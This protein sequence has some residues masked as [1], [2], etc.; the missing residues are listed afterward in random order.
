MSDQPTLSRRDRRRLQTRAEILAAARELLLEVGPEE[1][2]LRQVARR[3]D[4]SPAALY[5][6]FG[7]R[8]EIVG[9]LF[10]EAFEN[11]DA[12]LR[13]VPASLSPEKR[14]VELALAYMDFA[15]E[16]PMDLRCMLLSTSLE[17]PP[18]SAKAVGMG[19]ARL[20]GETFRAGMEQGYFPAGGPLSA[21]E[22]AYGLWALVQG[23]V[24]VASIDLSEVSEEISADPRKVIEAYVGM[25]ADGAGHVR[26]HR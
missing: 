25:L 15:R 22:M 4:F 3:A 23:M 17:L 5:N 12:Y 13:R 24:S 8:D 14:L 9:S 21:A 1:L 26:S 11:L 2:S 7:S 6:Y 20:I 10:A 16:N 18:S 19:A